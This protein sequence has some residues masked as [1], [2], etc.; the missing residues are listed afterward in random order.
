M[1]VARQHF[2]FL[3]DEKSQRYNVVCCNIWIPIITNQSYD[4]IYLNKLFYVLPLI[5]ILLEKTFL[6]TVVIST[7][8]VRAGQRAGSGPKA[9]PV[10]T[11]GWSGVTQFNPISSLGFYGLGLFG[12]TGVRVGL[13]GFGLNTILAWRYSIAWVC[14]RRKNRKERTQTKGIWHK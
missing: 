9:R 12:S 8:T 1:H 14:R 2:S 5:F 3:F 13:H 7:V 10:L 6:R 11:R 4:I